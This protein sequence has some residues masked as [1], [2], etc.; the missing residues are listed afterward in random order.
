MLGVKE[1]HGSTGT[2][3]RK[4]V[5]GNGTHDVETLSYPHLIPYGL[6]LPL[7]FFFFCMAFSHA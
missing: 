1:S 2:W 5:T 6:L 7:T 3:W 4:E